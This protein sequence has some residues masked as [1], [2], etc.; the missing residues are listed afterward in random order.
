MPGAEQAAGHAP[1]HP[2]QTDERDACH[3]LNPRERRP[4]ARPAEY[5]GRQYGS[6]VSGGRL[7]VRLR[8]GAAA[9]R[10][11][12]ANPDL[13]RAQL[14]FAGAWTAEWAF[15]AGLGV[16]AFQHGGAAAV[17]AVSL[18]R[19]LPAAVVTPFAS[20]YGDRWR[21]EQIIVAV[22]GARGAALGLMAVLAAL[23]LA[24][25]VVYGL[26]VVATIAGVLFRPVHSALVPSLCRTP[27]ELAGANVVR[28]MLDSLSTLLGPA[29]AAILLATSGPAA[30]FA[31]SAVA[32][33]WA[34]WLMLRVAPEV[35]EVREATA[36]P[37]A[38]APASV[39]A[40][41][42][43]GSPAHRS[44]TVTSGCS[45]CSPRSRR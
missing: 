22:T 18:L 1:P 35:M 15:T 17:G 25:A 6:T 34:A 28:G 5:A 24:V 9:F 41:L 27:T 23:D 3:A 38:A 12:W 16:L 19:M 13:R 33:L 44:A 21:R 7:R 26:A 29:L 4:E 8:G 11:S 32:C 43:D 42:V 45:S 30:V 10:G 20:V 37:A 39:A 36:E 14:C 40:D 31:V 2:A